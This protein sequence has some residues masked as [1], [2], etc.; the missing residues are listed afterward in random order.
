[1]SSMSHP[2]DGL[3]VYGP[4]HQKR[5]VV[6][7]AG[8][9]PDPLWPHSA[10]VCLSIV[11]NYEEGGEN[12]LLHGDSGSEGLLS[13]I[14]GCPPYP[15]QRHTN[16][17]SLYEYGSRAGF[18][19]LHRIM[20]ERDMPVTVFAVG[21]A[22]ERNAQACAAMMN[23]GWEVSSH[24]YRWIDYQ[25]IDP[26][27][28]RE[29][30]RKTVE[31]HERMVGARPMGI[32]QGKPNE[33]TRK[34]VVEEGFMY[35][36]DAYN[37]DLPYWDCGFGKPHLIIPYTLDNNDMRYNINNGF[38][39]GGQF[40][41]YLKDALDTLLEEGRA[42]S[43]KMMTVGLHCR[44]VGKPGRTQGLIKFLDYV[45]SKGNEVWVARRDE[46]ANHWYKN[47]YPKG[48]GEPPRVELVGMRTSKL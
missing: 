3:A 22:L 14:I 29:H 41:Q 24:G 46:I 33:N 32:Y 19:R 21:M 9:P 42:G 34:I 26:I 28:E 23:A 47:H 10:K 39:C 20:T 11:I 31:I 48:C 25:N 1:M 18:W 45:R 6:G 8:N 37:D 2:N 30:V 12:C 16:M 4:D 43:P 35:D 15:G 38:S 17:E 40:Y 7:S 36:N 5:D 44:I 13:E 27:T